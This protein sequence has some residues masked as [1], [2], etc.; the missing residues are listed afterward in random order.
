MNVS[1]I[2]GATSSSAA[3]NGNKQITQATNLAS[4]TSND[5]YT[6]A[7]NGNITKDAPPAGSATNFTYASGGNELCN[8]STSATTCGGTL[9]NGAKYAFTTNGQRASTTPYVSSLAG[10]TT[11]Y[12]WNSFGQL[13][14][15]GPSSSPISTPCGTLPFNHDFIVNNIFNLGRGVG[16]RYSAQHQ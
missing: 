14:S 5:V 1:S 11:N 10:T 6:L 16:R 3:Y 7:I 13:C 2:N 12:N 8:T 9:A 15:S 4:S